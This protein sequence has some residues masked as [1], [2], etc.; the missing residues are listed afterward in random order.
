LR[1]ASSK[2]TLNNCVVISGTKR[3]TLVGTPDLL[4]PEARFALFASSLYR[5]SWLLCC[6]SLSRSRALLTQ[7]ISGKPYGK[8][9]DVWALGM[10]VRR[11]DRYRFFA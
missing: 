6:S 9:V 8:E 5:V 7:V 4:A 10:L 11:T 1:A 2:R 3:T